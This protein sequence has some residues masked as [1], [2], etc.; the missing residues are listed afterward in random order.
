MKAVRV[1]VLAMVVLGIGV[2]GYWAGRVALEPPVDPLDVKVE[3]LTYV[4]GMGSVGRSLNFTALA[5]WELEDLGQGSAVGVVTSVELADGASLVNSGDVI[6]TVG[7]RP[8]VVAEGPVPMFRS[9]GMRA[10]GADVAQLQGLLAGL[11]FFS[12]EI[13]GSFGTATRAAVRDWQESLGVERS[14]VVEAGDI[15]FVASLPARVVVSE[16]IWV[17][18]RLH[19]GETVLQLVPEVPS[20]WIRL[21]P[22]QSALVPL[23]A[24]VNVEY[25]DGVWPGRIERAVENPEFGWLDLVLVGREGGPVCGADCEEWVGL[26]GRNDYWA[27][28]IV[29]PQTEGPVVPVAAIGSDPGGN[30]FVTLEDG[31]T[32]PIAIVESANG[33]AVVEG[34]EPGTVI[35]LPVES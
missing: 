13:D 11:G 8:V 35:L 29:I 28:I 31:S 10:E 17:G 3:P 2:A 22:E 14:G 33:I 23:T 26:K 12:G 4:V 24:D 15:V 7:L 6:Y 18:A 32:V 21:A 19:G 27:E 1:L 20:F 9:L 5:E 30:P 34:V 16:S 25:G